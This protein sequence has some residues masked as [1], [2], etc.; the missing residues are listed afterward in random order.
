MNITYD[1]E[2]GRN[3]ELYG[4]QTDFLN[5][6]KVFDSRLS[7]MV[8]T[9]KDRIIT[10]K[11]KEEKKR[12]L[13]AGILLEEVLQKNSLSSSIVCTQE[14][15]KPYL[16]HQHEFYFNISH[17]GAY[18]FCVT[19]RQPVGVDIQ[20]TKKTSIRLAERFFQKEEWKNIIDR[21][22][23]KQ[24]ELFFRYWV[25]KEGYL[26]LTGEGIKGGLDR[27]YVDLDSGIIRDSLSENKAYFK[28]YGKLD[29]YRMAVVSYQDVFPEDYIL[30]T[31]L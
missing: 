17:S 7:E 1:G 4:L 30:Y 12:L 13:A 9:R 14:G 8:E 16:P 29:N 15:G 31:C 2:K 22:K 6:D 19:D 3:M 5:D 18:V 11:S 26:K 21:E 27:F 20:I 25:V 24:E 10:C 23:E 28:E